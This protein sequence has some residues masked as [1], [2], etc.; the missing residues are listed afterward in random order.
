MGDRIEVQTAG[1]LTL[2]GV[3]GGGSPGLTSGDAVE[4]FVRP[5]AIEIGRGGGAGA[6][7]ENVVRGTIDSLLFNGADSRALVR[8]GEGQMIQAALP[9][10]RSTPVPQPGETVDLVWAQRQTTCFPA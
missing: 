7:A 10:A 2:M 6:A 4:V 8:I 9:Q 5:G 3:P 1:G